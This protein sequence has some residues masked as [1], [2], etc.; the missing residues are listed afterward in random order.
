MDLTTTQEDARPGVW[1]GGRDLVLELDEGS[2][3]LIEPDT[4]AC[5]NSQPIHAIR[6]SSKPAV[7]MLIYLICPLLLQVWG[8]GR[9]SGKDFAYVSRDKVKQCH[10]SR[11]CHS[12][13][14]I[15]G[16]AATRVPRVPLPAARPHHRQRAAGHLQE[17]PDRAQ[18]RTELQ[19]AHREAHQRAGPRPSRACAL[20]AAN[21][22]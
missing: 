17:D 11:H 1:G 13:V 12:R 19:Q 4:G 6:V 14:C 8:V 20:G 5:L 21:Q 15:P 7:D 3:K 10:V 2:L 22:V 16:D 9:D 18:P